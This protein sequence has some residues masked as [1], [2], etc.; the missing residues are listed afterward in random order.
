[1]ADEKFLADHML[2]RLSKWLRMMGFDV[3]YPDKQMSDNQIIERCESENLIL[4]TRDHELYGRF[5]RSILIVSE[6]FK[7]QVLEFIAHYPPDASSYF[8]RCPE[9]NSLLSEAG[10]P[11]NIEGVPDSVKKA[12]KKVWVC[13]QCGKVYWQG[14]H[15][16]R[17]V[18]QIRKFERGMK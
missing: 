5:P 3:G 18:S 1:M 15:Y 13:N 16:D 11:E 10:D 7:D 12:Q 2:R 14:S 8:T 6:D 17:I 9:C 4:L